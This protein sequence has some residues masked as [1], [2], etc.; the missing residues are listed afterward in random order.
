MP[1][2]QSRVPLPAFALLLFLHGASPAQDPPAT[3]PATDEASPPARR[4]QGG[5]TEW[6]KM[7]GDWGGART[8]LENLGIRLELDV[9]Q[10]F[11]HNAHGGAA[12]DN[13][14]RYSGSGDLTL[15]LDT[16]KMGLWPAGTFVINAEPKWGNGLNRKVGTLLPVNYDATKPG[17]DECMM[18]LSE[19]FW[20]QGI[21]QGPAGKAAVV[22]GRV[23]LARGFDTN[24]FANDERTAFMNVGLRNNPQLGAVVGYTPLAAALVYLPTDWLTIWTAVGDSDG[25][26]KRTGFDTAFHGDAENIAVAHEWQIK[27]R[28]FDLPGTQRLAF[29]WSPKNLPYV[30]PRSPLAEL[31]PLLIRLL[32]LETVNRLSPYLP[33]KRAKDNVIVWYSFDQYLY[34]EPQDPTQGVGLF[35]RFGWAREDVNAIEQF[36]SIGVGGKGIL[37]ERDRDRFGIGYYHMD[38][39]D[40]LP[41]MIHSEHGIECYY[42]IQ[43]T[44][45]MTV[46]PDLQIIM[47]PGG[48][49]DRDVALVWGFRVQMNL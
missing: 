15:T 29:G 24:A 21:Y 10:I 4:Y 16:Q 23:D 7:T 17:D 32:G 49:S 47:N 31:S 44:G 13:G 37:P 25:Q 36:Y 35:G 48:T 27:V 28:P 11:Q 5:W 26:A 6:P 38:L 2:L 40:R 19:W 33:Y 46:S 30:D 9:T 45:W 42:S 1:R 39:S 3:G 34:C 18:T 22:L 41:P 20:I 12:T 8:D 43:V 14:A